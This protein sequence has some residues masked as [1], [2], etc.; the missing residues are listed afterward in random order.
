M[1]TLTTGDPRAAADAAH[2]YTE[3]VMEAADSPAVRIAAAEME[4]SAHLG[5]Q[6]N[7]PAAAAQLDAEMAAAETR[8]EVGDRQ[9]AAARDELA[10]ETLLWLASQ[11]ETEAEAG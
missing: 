9:A 2:A 4:R 10:A 5:L 11:A 7:D 6:E 3:R 1:P 8:P